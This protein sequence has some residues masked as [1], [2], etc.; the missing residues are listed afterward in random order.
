MRVGNEDDSIDPGQHGLSGEC[1]KD[2]PGDGIDVKAGFEPLDIVKLNGEEVKE[3]GSVILRCKRNQFAPLLG[4]Q[5]YMDRL[6]VGGL[7]TEGG[8]VIHNLNIDLF[9]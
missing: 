2:L 7:S 6:N 8:T 4:M 3:K 5:A 9:L 1:I